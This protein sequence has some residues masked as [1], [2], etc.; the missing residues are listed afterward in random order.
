MAMEST[1]QGIEA[2]V[3]SL[4]ERVVARD[5]YDLVDIEF[6]REPAGW[7]LTLFIDKQGGVNLDDCQRVSQVV[8]TVL[9]VED[10][11]PHRYNLQVSS[12]GLDRPLKRDDDFI[13][14][15]GRL[16]RIVTCEP[17]S[18][19]RNFFGRLMGAGE[20]NA[21]EPAPTAASGSDSRIVLHMSDDGGREHRIPVRAVKRAH[22]V[23]EWPEA[24]RQGSRKRRSSSGRK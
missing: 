3:R 17:I 4:A 2:R 5:G 19:Q 6:R 22:I 7:T 16:V 1:A 23:Y 12:P 18:G 24:V 13:A 9:D 10:P 14:A 20:E 11:I 21:D 15:R 8:G